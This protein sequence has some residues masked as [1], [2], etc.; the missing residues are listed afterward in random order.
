MS[1]NCYWFLSFFLSGFNWLANQVGL[2]VDTV[3]GYELVKPNGD[4]VPVTGFDVDLFFA[5]KVTITSEA[6]S[7]F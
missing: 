2:A 7:V 6:L 3:V 5:L 1:I 4:I